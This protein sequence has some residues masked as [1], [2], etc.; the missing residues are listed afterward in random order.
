MRMAEKCQLRHNDAAFESW[1]PLL[2]TNMFY[3]MTTYDLFKT[4]P[5][6]FRA[7]GLLWTVRIHA[8]A[9]HDCWG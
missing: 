2:K 7:T 1:R 3:G 9:T 5:T 8:H 6:V 4:F